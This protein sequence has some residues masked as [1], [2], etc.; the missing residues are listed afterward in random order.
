MLLA[1]DEVAEDIHNIVAAGL[2]LI[3]LGSGQVLLHVADLRRAPDIA[4]FSTVG[5]PLTISLLSF[6]FPVL[7]GRLLRTL[8]HFPLRFLEDN[9]MVGYTSVVGYSLRGLAV[10]FF[11]VPAVLLV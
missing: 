10:E 8:L 7:P 11:T 6:F 3:L 4:I 5:Q 1:V 9:L 2:V